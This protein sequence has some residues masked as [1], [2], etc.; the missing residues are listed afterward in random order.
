[1]CTLSLYFY[2]VRSRARAR[3]RLLTISD[4]PHTKHSGAIPAAVVVFLLQI[5]MPT[6]SSYGS[7]RKRARLARPI[8]LANLLTFRLVFVNAFPQCRTLY[9]I[10]L[11]TRSAS[12]LDNIF[13]FV[14]QLLLLPDDA[15][16]QGFY[17]PIL[18]ARS[19]DLFVI[20]LTECET[21]AN[22]LHFDCFNR[23][24]RHQ[25][26]KEFM[27]L[28]V[29]KYRMVL[30]EVDEFHAKCSR[31]RIRY[32]QIAT[33]TVISN[34]FNVTEFVQYAK[35]TNVSIFRAA[36]SS[37]H[38]ARSLPWQSGS[39]TPPRMDFLQIL[40]ARSRIAFIN[41]SRPMA[42]WNARHMY[43]RTSQQRRV[44]IAIHVGRCA[45]AHN[46]R[47]QVFTIS[48]SNTIHSFNGI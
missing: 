36:F 2:L 38:A 45:L 30:K 40:I 25:G 48:S 8:I 23:P 7:A 31:F 22:I 41:K 20:E 6:L 37:T 39:P 35:Q 29:E 5:A 42:E 14:L 4:R 17:C 21:Y 32:A 27:N 43:D 1:M 9:T 19:R 13:G 33:R 44:W 18:C 24:E 16:C 47:A 11:S 10:A 34:E 26:S 46:V 28:V 15:V 3:T 12:S